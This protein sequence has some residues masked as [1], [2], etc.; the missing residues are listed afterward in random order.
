M[1]LDQTHGKPLWNFHS[2][3]PVSAP[4]ITYAVGGK[5]YVAVIAGGKTRALIG[6]V[7]EPQLAAMSKRPRLVAC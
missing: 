6:M 3:T 1:A 7:K 4:P 5:Q 2:G